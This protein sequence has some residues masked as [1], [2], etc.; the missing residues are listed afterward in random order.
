MAARVYAICDRCKVEHLCPTHERHTVE[1]VIDWKDSTPFAKVDL[2]TKCLEGF[3][4]ASR[5][6]FVSEEGKTT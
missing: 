4:L 1:V 5:A 6:W 2:C 3:K